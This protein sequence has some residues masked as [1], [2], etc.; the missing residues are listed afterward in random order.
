M[1]GDALPLHSSTSLFYFQK[2][3][4]T[5]LECMEGMHGKARWK[6]YDIAF[7]KLT[8]PLILCLALRLCG[9]P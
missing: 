4:Q 3:L 1:T 2:L 6:R 5:H 9:S 8:S 7:A